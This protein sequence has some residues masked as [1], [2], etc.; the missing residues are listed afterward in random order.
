MASPQ[1]PRRRRGRHLS[2]DADEG[3][4]TNLNR[5]RHA[6][7]R[8]DAAMAASWTNCHAVGGRRWAARADQ[9]TQPETNEPAGGYAFHHPA[10][11]RNV[12]PPSIRF[13]EPLRWWSLDRRRRLAVIMRLRDRLQ[14][15]ILRL[16][17]NGGLR[18]LTSRGGTS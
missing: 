11:L 13:A 4:E 8:R 9:R 1:D 5:D 6:D 14:N 3:A 17:R 2:N 15:D 10:V 18:M 7:A 16:G 12:P